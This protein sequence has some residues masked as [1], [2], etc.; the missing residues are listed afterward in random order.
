MPRQQNL[1]IDHLRVWQAEA[2]YLNFYSG[3]RINDS[4]IDHCSN[5]RL[6]S[7]FDC[8]AKSVRKSRNLLT[9]RMGQPIL[10]KELCA[11]VVQ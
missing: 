1:W 9:N 2:T 5:L 7:R 4:V 10:R 8:R 11:D 6:S 3:A